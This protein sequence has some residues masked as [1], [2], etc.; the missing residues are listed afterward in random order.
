M[1]GFVVETTPLSLSKSPIQVSICEKWAKKLVVFFFSFFVL[2]MRPYMQLPELFRSFN[3]VFL[4]F[5]ANLSEM[6]CKF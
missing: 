3:M 1:I 2:K 4:N 5:S 6:A